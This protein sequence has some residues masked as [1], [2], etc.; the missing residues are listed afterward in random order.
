MTDWCPPAEIADAPDET[1]GGFSYDYDTFYT[2]EL[3]AKVLVC[4]THP[5][6]SEKPS[7]IKLV[8]GVDGPQGGVRFDQYLGLDFSKDFNKSQHK[9]FLNALFPGY[10]GGPDHRAGRPV[11]LSSFVGLWCQILVKK[12]LDTYEGRAPRNRPRVVKFLGPLDGPTAVDVSKVTVAYAAVD[13]GASRGSGRPAAGARPAAKPVAQAAPG[14]RPAPAPASGMPARPAA[15]PVSKP[16]QQ[17]LVPQT[18]AGA[19]D[20]DDDLPY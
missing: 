4:E 10:L 3:P 1:G 19:H 6:D 15:P 8:L 11:D 2:G 18:E 9:A 5:V 16:V 17:S 7:S 20:A 14:A 13:A 12:E